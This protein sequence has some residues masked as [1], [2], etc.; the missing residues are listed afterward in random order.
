MKGVN[1]TPAT[2]T[3]GTSIHLV[4]SIGGFQRYTL[5]RARKR[6]V[7]AISGREKTGKSSLALS[8]PGPIAY[9]NYDVG[10]EGVIERH[11]KHKQIYASQYRVN[12]PPGM[13]GREQIA[14]KANE[15]WERFKKDIRAAY[16]STVIRSIVVDTDTET[17]EHIRIAQFAQLM[18]IK[19][20]HY[21]PV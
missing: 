11:C 7:L 13:T 8:A 17:W 19:Q 14:L 1:M 21:G 5:G 12:I 10:L 2:G 15:V 20:H 6:L 9:A 4:D 3:P 18:Q 16:A